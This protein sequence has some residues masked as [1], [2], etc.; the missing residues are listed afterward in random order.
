[1]EIKER[2]EYLK[3]AKMIESHDKKAKAIGV[4]A[5]SILN[6][7]NTNNRKHREDKSGFSNILRVCLCIMRHKKSREEIAMRYYNLVLNTNTE[8]LSESG[9]VELNRWQSPISQIN[10][11]MLKSMKNETVFFIY[12]EDNN[13]YASF[14]FNDIQYEFKET[15]DFIMELLNDGFLIQGV[16]VEPFEITMSQFIENMVEGQRRDFTSGHNGR[17]TEE[18]HLW[19]YPYYRNDPKDLLYTYAEEIVDIE[20]EDRKSL[21]DDSFWNE[22]LNIQNHKNQS[23]YSGNMVHYVISARSTGAVKNMTSVL[24]KNLFLADRLSSRRMEIISEINPEVY[25]KRNY[26]E[27]IIENNRG[28][29][30]VFDLSEKFGKAATDYAMTAKYIE[31]LLKKYRNYCLFIFT[32]NMDNPGFSYYILPNLSKYVIPVKLREGT[33]NRRDAINYMKSLISRSEYGEYANQATEF[34]KQFPGDEFTQSDVLEAYEQ[35]E[36]WC[37]NKNVLKAYDFDLS[38]DFILDRDENVK[39]SYDKLQNLI[40]LDLVK[41]QIDTIIAADVVEK[42]RKKRKGKNY[43]ASSMHMIFGGNPGSAKT[44]VAKLFGGIAKEKGILKSGAFVECG[45]NDLDGLGCAYRIR[46]AFQAAKGGVLFIDEAYGIRSDSAATALIQEMENQRD[47]VI[48]ILAGYNERMQEFLE[49]NEG[50]KS[51]VPHWVEF[52]DYTADELTDIFKLMLAE[53]GFDA[54]EDAIK[55]AHYIFEKVRNTDNFGNGRF[56]RNLLEQAM[57]NQAVRL[58][59]LRE[60]ASDIRKKE[61]FLLTR[62]DI[63]SLNEGLTEERAYG[64]AK[65]ELDNMIGLA[66]VKSVISKAIANYKLNKLCLERGINRN[67]SSL[68]MVFTGNPGT[69]KTTVARLFAEIM[70]DEKVLSTGKFVEVG[71]ADLVGDHVGATAKLVKRKFKEAQGGVLFVDEAYSLCDSYEHGFGDEAINTLV[72]EMENHR[73]DVIVIFAG[74]PKPMKEFLDRNP[75]MLSRIA[76]H[77]EFE[78]YT[79]DELCE[80]TKLMLSQKQMSITEE[81]MDRLRSNYEVAMK[82]NDYGNGRFVRKMLEEAEMNLAERI[83]EMGDI[84]FNDALITTLEASD[85]EEYKAIEKNEKIS[86]GFAC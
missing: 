12:R 7:Q 3:I 9:R 48:V 5:I 76:F 15:Y 83:L 69:A 41:K 74:Y 34:M 10:E 79:L 26:L 14:C 53:R 1:M 38:E 4:N 16:K 40:G 57:Q 25:S 35:F 63:A 30:I 58:L 6:P 81:A 27:E 85:I 28:G 77:V 54:T 64:T 42:E 2:L 84:E 22:I 23:E 55:E 82:S 11:Y 18:A 59:S 70:K 33:G 13:M 24:V 17:I 86:I 32:Y 19:Y 73:D 51:R 68:H 50:M 46:K 61:M 39:S 21:Y 29:V 37:L 36:S 47:N 67:K 71:R 75:G 66:S 45:G 72:Q 31:N 43:Q 80:I 52:P 62:E 44:T 60:Q 65:K 56:V 8:L 20:G 78:D 49:T